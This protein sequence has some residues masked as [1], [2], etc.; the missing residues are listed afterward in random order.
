MTNDAEPIVKRGRDLMVG[1]HLTEAFKAL[2]M[3][4]RQNHRHPCV[5]QVFKANWARPVDGV[6]WVIQV[7]KRGSGTAHKTVPVTRA[8]FF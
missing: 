1:G 6:I 7:Q 4:T 8:Q 2:I 3:A 5:P